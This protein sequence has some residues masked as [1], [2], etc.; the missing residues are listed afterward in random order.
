MLQTIIKL[1]KLESNTG[2]IESVPK[3]P[4]LI[5]DDKF[6]K[7]VK[8]I[9]EFPE[10]LEYRELIVFPY[11]KKFIVLAGNMRFEAL[12][13]LGYKEAICKVLPEDISTEKLKELI[14]KDNI[15]YGELDWD[16]LVNEWDEVKL[17]EW[18]V[19]EPIPNEISAK[20]ENFL[21]DG[22][23]Y[24]E[25]NADV[26]VKS[27]LLNFSLDN[28]EA[29]VEM[30]KEISKTEQVPVGDYIMSLYSEHKNWKL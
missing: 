8:S 21:V 18:G 23:T 16:L 14:I 12:K 29:G 24:F 19:I 13:H 4:R 22:G 27:V 7:L 25:R 20:T 9:Q 15:S 17:G 26:K 2:Q 3:N 1:T 6:E 30:I 5:K 28:Y 11:N 10:M